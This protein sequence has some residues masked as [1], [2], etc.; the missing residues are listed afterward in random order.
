MS[1]TTIREILGDRELYAVKIETNLRD[2]AQVMAEHKAGAVVVLAE[3]ALVGILSER[4]IVFR[5][6]AQGLP[7][8]T[9]VV[10]QIMTRDPVTVNI[11]DGISDTLAARLG[12]VFRHLPVMD[13]DRVAGVL[14][15][16][17]IPPEYVMMY[18]RFR[19][20]SGSRANEV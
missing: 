15:F 14:S 17:D 18:E 4:D 20:M 16:R 6:V 7:S 9:T 5:A 2:A 8:D 11:D 10:E 3:G 12:D 13:G 19:E 1:T